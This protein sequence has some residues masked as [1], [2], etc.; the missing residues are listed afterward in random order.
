VLEVLDREPLVGDDGLH[1]V[2]D[3]D[4]PIALIHWLPQHGL[5]RTEV[6]KTERSAFKTCEEAGQAT[7]CTGSSKTACTSRRTVLRSDGGQVAD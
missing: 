7:G 2:A 1:Q 3:G 5:Q 4:E 6:M